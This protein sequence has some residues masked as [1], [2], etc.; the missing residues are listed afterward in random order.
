MLYVTRDLELLLQA[1][2][3]LLSFFSLEIIC[4]GAYT[5]TTSVVKLVLRYNIM[6]E[7]DY[8]GLSANHSLFM[9][10][11][12]LRKY[13]ITFSTRLASVDRHSK[14]A[15]KLSISDSITQSVSLA[16]RLHL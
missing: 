13:K 7:R 12:S 10:T 9:K 2:S 14:K 15:S 3:V 8:N 4:V 6:N 11:I 16:R 1:E 5:K